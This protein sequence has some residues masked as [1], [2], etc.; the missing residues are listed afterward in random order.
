MKFNVSKAVQ[1]VGR[2]VD[3]VL[4]AP[5]TDKRGKMPVMLMSLAGQSISHNIISGTVAIKEGF[6]IDKIYNIMVSEG[7]ENDYGRQF[8]FVNLGELQGVELAKTIK[9][10]GAVEIEDVSAD[11]AS[12]TTATTNVNTNAVVEGEEEFGG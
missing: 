10:Y 7:A 9:E 5:K 4:I 6:E 8:S 11:D 3:G 1:Y 2:K 12:T